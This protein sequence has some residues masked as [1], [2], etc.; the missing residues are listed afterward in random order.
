MY[1]SC[2]PPWYGDEYELWTSSL[3]YIFSHGLKC[4]R[5]RPN[6][7]LTICLWS[8]V[9]QKL[10][11][12]QLVAEVELYLQSRVCLRGQLYLF[13]SP[14]QPIPLN[15]SRI[16]WLHVFNMIFIC[17]RDKRQWFAFISVSKHDYLLELHL[18]PSPYSS[19]PAL[20]RFSSVCDVPSLRNRVHLTCVCTTKWGDYKYPYIGLYT[21]I[22]R[23]IYH[24]Y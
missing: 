11:V 21:T 19:F 2:Y 7:N 4:S 3:C 15:C 8:R 10:L 22:R 20:R 16:E 1:S 24:W 18:S 13:T 6:F 12:A 5:Q 17:F 14:S 9:L 23:E